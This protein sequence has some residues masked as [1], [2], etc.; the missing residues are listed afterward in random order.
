ME[1]FKKP[2]GVV[3]RWQSFENVTGLI[4]L[5]TPYNGLDDIQPISEGIRDMS[6]E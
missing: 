6:E 4:Y 2:A 1:L 5:D 3:T